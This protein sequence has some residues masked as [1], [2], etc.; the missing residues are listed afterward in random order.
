MLSAKTLAFSQPGASGPAGRSGRGVPEDRSQIIL[1]PLAGVVIK[2]NEFIIFR[3]DAVMDR[4]EF[5]VMIIHGGS[6]AAGEWPLNRGTRLLPCISAGGCKPAS[7]RK[8]G[9]KSTLRTIWSETEPSGILPGKR[10][11]KGMRRDCSYMKRLSNQPCSP[12]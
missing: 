3:A 9:A 11:S 12:R 7:S 2:V 6:P 1:F 10:A 5:I 4:G 8:V